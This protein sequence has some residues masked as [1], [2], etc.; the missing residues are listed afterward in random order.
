MVD[1]L[2]FT[3]AV[4]VAVQAGSRVLPFRLPTAT[5]AERAGAEMAAAISARRSSAR[6]AVT[7]SPITPDGSWSPS[8]AQLREA[9]FA[10]RLVLPSPHC[11]IIS[12]LITGA[13]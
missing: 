3:T 4:S 8:P 7:R 11:N 2:P 12:A 13:G 10:S 6:L 9:P 5:A 1:V